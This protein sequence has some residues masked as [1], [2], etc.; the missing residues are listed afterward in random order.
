MISYFYPPLAGMGMLRT[1]KFAKFLP[2]YNWI[3]IILTPKNA[4]GFV[5]CE[6][7]EGILDD[8]EII[9]SRYFDLEAFIFK[10]FGLRPDIPVAAQIIRTEK[11]KTAKRI[12]L[13]RLPF[14]SKFIRNWLFF[15]D[16]NIGWY[17]FALEKGLEYI[18]HRKVDLIYS[19]SP[20]ETS[21]L[22]AYSLKRRT[23]LP[24]VA[25]FRDLWTQN[26]Y[27]DLSHL[28][29]QVERV[30]EKKI[31]QAA[32]SSIVVS[33]P[34]ADSFKALHEDIV[35]L[36]YVGVLESNPGN[37]KLRIT[38]EGKELLEK[39][40]DKLSKDECEKISKVIDEIRPRIVS[41]DA[42]QELATML[43]RRRR[44]GRRRFF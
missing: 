37:K 29:C 6:E 35:A 19:T 4:R 18:K 33:K 34:L 20:P 17:P 15:P 41:I 28:R 8:I 7:S 44:R 42:E 40:S 9:R 10:L 2:R 21:H 30:L 31:V 3:P 25:D 14:F 16:S 26:L 43:S 27:R 36:L 38:G 12:L 11:D 39:V 13:K 1:L 24:W 23:G 5:Y 22:I 32:D